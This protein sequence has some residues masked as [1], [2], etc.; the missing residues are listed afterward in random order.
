M[1]AARSARR[2]A[3]PD[4]GAGGGRAARRSPRRH[5]ERHGAG[6]GPVSA[7]RREIITVGKVSATPT[8][9]RINC[10]RGRAKASAS[11][12]RYCCSLCG[13]APSA[14]K[15]TS[16]REVGR[17]ST[18]PA[19]RQNQSRISTAY[20]ARARRSRAWRPHRGRTTARLTPETEAGHARDSR[21]RVSSHENHDLE[22]QRREG[23]ARIRAHLP[24]PGRPRH[25]LPAGDQERRRGLSRPPPSRSSATISPSTARRASTASPCCRSCP[26]TR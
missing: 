4:E 15:S 26:S 3:A 13:P 23:A 1:V 16:S 19:S 12:I 22:H 18:R 14:W 6:Q 11:Q 24:A 7:S 8:I 10:V 25:R 20:G 9:S 5:R 21:L 2:D 17:N